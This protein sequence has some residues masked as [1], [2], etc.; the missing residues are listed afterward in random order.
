MNSVDVVVLNDMH[1]M[2]FP[3]AATIALNHAKYISKNLKVEFWHTS[4]VR[5]TPYES[6]RLRIRSFYRNSRVDE[7]VTRFMSTRIFNEFFPSLLFFQI[8]ISIMVLRPKVVWVNQI[9]VRIPRTITLCLNL[10]RIRT[11]QTFHDFGVISPRKLYPADLIK[12]NKARLSA[13]NVVNFLYSIRRRCLI[14][15]ANLN[16]QNICVGK[17]QLDIYKGFGVKKVIQIPN[18]IGNCRCELDKNFKKV[19]NTV[20]FAGRA[21]GKGFESICHIVK[22]NSSWKLAAAGGPE[23]NELGLKYLGFDQFRYLGFLN[24]AELFKQ[25]HQSEIVAVLSECLDVYPTIGLEAF[26]H[27]STPLTSPSTG[28]AD[29]VKNSGCGIVYD[30]VNPIIDLNKLKVEINQQPKFPIEQ[31]ELRTSGDKYYSIL[32][33]A[34]PTTN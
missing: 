4:N 24:P 10:F 22:M 11:I 25:I 5:G 29:L 17:I 23:L 26:M 14:T 20:L 1:P 16:F 33:S 30:E 28:I 9:G 13:S 2:D 32:D 8:F 27:G 18:G 34:S 12:T 31:I 3:G 19:P 15:I 7:F 21:M 6:E